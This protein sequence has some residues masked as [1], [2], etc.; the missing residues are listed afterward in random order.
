MAYFKR[1]LNT[2]R[3]L[4]RC[5]WL[6]WYPFPSVDT[7]IAACSSHSHWPYP[8][9][10]VL[11]LRRNVVVRYTLLLPSPPT[12]VVFI[13][14]VSIIAWSNWVFLLSLNALLRGKLRN[15]TS[16][17]A[18]FNIWH[19]FALSE[20]L[21]LNNWSSQLAVIALIFI[22]K[23]IFSFCVFHR[24][25]FVLISVANSF[26]VIFGDHLMGVVNLVT[27]SLFS[28]CCWSLQKPWMIWA[29]VVAVALTAVTAVV[30]FRTWGKTYSNKQTNKH[31]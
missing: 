4:C 30:L 3:R 20:W 10:A 28:L 14:I 19:L 2:H 31:T 26:C 24:L 16:N 29:P 11:V 7:T 25:C 27:F 8:G 13:S 22:L 17:H 9:F 6:L 12:S 21:T 5:S 15:I 18:A 23:S 1:K